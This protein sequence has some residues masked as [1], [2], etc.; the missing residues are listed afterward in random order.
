[1]DIIDFVLFIYNIY[2]LFIN[3]KCLDISIW[4]LWLKSKYISILMKYFLKKL[5][6][7]EKNLNMLIFDKNI[8]LKIFYII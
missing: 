3:Y 6:I 1:M 4:G 8:F 7:V 5:Y 2:Y